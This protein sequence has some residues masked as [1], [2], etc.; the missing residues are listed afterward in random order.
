M[1]ATGAHVSAVSF[2]DDAKVAFNLNTLQGEEYTTQNVA[3]R[4]NSISLV[5][6]SPRIDVA[7]QKANYLFRIKT[8]MRKKATKVRIDLI[9]EALI[10]Y[11]IQ[12]VVLF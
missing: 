7:L 2:S 8:G 11:E 5:N 4:I 6:R 10:Q 3:R 1:S 9:L 12:P